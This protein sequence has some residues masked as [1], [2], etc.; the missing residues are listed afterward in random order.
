MTTEDL[1]KL[2]DTEL[3]EAYEK[4]KL[5]LLKLRLAVASRQSKN[6]AELKDLRKM[7]ARIKTIKRLMEIEKIKEDP[8]SAVT[9]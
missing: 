5:S 7:I 2:S 3:L 9:H 8:K 1:K 4:G 6:S